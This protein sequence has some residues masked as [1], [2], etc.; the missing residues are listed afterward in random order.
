MV[1]SD[2]SA[3]LIRI[4]RNHYQE[5]IPLLRLDAQAIPFR[6]QSFDTVL[7]FEAI[8]YLADLQAFARECHRI[9]RPQ[10]LLLLCTANKDLPDFN[11]SPYSFFYPNP[12][13]FVALLRPLGFQVECFADS[14]VDYGNRKQ[15]ILSG[16]KKTM[17]RFDLMPKTMV[18]KKIFKRLIF[19][20]LVPLPEEILEDMG[21][22]TGPTPIPSEKKDAVHKV[23][24]ALARKR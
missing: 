22:P 23:I 20:K 10:G 21:L 18:A 16:I 6:D 1:G 9:L 11:P 14:P 17:V 8:Y 4:A 13:D 24:F 7:L 5:R 3:S 2:Y 12:P 15:K 19:G